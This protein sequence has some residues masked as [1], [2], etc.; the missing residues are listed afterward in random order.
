MKFFKTFIFLVLY[1][2]CFS[3]DYYWVGNS[4]NWS[5]YSNHWA[6]TSGGST[7][8]NAVPSINDDIYFDVNSF[9]SAGQVVT[10]DLS[11][12]NVNN[13]DFTGVTNSPTLNSGIANSLY[14]NGDWIGSLGIVNQL[15]GEIR[16]ISSNSTNI[17]SFG[18][19][20][21]GPIVFDGYGTWELLSDFNSN[22]SL[23]VKTGT[24]N[25][26]NFNVECEKIKI[27][28]FEPRTINAG[29]S[30]IT[31]TGTDSAFVASPI[32]LYLTLTNADLIFNNTSGN[33]V[34]FYSGGSSILYPKITVSSNAFELVE[35]STVS[36]F[37]AIPGTKIY[38]PVNNTCNFTSFNID[39]NCALPTILAANSPDT[40]A[41]LNIAGGTTVN[42]IHIQDIQAGGGAFVANNS[43]DNGNN[44]GW[45][46][47]EETSNGNVYWIG[48]TGNWSNPSNWSTNC[49]PGPNDTIIFNG[50]S[51]S[52]VND[53]VTL[54][55]NAYGN[56][57][58]WIGVSG[59]PDFSGTG[60]NLNLKESILFD[61]NM[62]SSFSGAIYLYGNNN[63][64][65]TTNGVLLNNNL[66]LNKQS[67]CV[68]SDTYSSTKGIELI[69]G[70]I[71]FGNFTHN[72]QN[73][74]SKDNTYTRTIDLSSS[75]LFLNGI[76][77]VLV[78][79]SPNLVVTSTSS[80]IEFN[81][82][83]NS[84]FSFFKS[85]LVNYDTV[86]IGNVSTHLYGSNSFKLLKIKGG[87]EFLI[88][89]GTEQNVDSIVTESS[90][91]QPSI[92]GTVSTIGTPASLNK[93]GY[94]TLRLN[95]LTVNHVVANALSGAYY[96]LIDGNLLNTTT[97]WVDNNTLTGKR[98]YWRGN[99][100]NWNDITKW[101]SPL[102]TPATCLPTIKDSVYFD[103]GSF[104]LPNQIVTLNV[105]AD[106]KIMDWSGSG[107]FSPTLS[108]ENSLNIK[109]DFITDVG[110]NYNSSSAYPSLNFIPDGNKSLF[111]TN[112]VLFDVNVS[113]D[114]AVLT[115]SVELNGTL[116]LG[117]DKAL[118]LY[119]GTFLSNNDSIFVG[120]FNS[121]SIGTQ[122]ADLGSSYIEV[123]S[124]FDGRGTGSLNFSNC[125]IHFGNG[126]LFSEFFGG[127]RLFNYLVLYGS[128]TSII[129]V[130]NSNS[131]DNFEIKKGSRVQFEA[132]ETQTISTSLLAIGNCENDTIYL[133]SISVNTPSTI[134]CTSPSTIEVCN[135]TDISGSGIN[136]LFGNDVGGNS[137]L[138]FLTTL[139]ATS[140]FN[141]SFDNC[142]GMPA[143]FTNTS[144]DYLSGTALTY[145]W[146]FGDG[147]T[148]TLTN[149]SH[150][151]A[152]SDLFKLT[153]KS[154]YTNGCYNI[155]EDSIRVNDANIV[156]TSSDI[157][158][159]ICAGDMVSFSVSSAGASNFNFFL[160][161][162]SVL[163]GTNTNY[164]NSNLVNG[165]SV[166][167]QVTLNGCVKSSTA[168]PFVVHN[169][170]TTN[171]MSSDS[172]NIICEGETVTFTASGADVYLFFID[173]VQ[174]GSYSTTNILTTTT[175]QNNETISVRG[176]DTITDCFFDAPVSYNFTV[177]PNPIPTV[178]VDDADLVICQSDLVNF[179]ASGANEY[180]FFINGI[181]QQGS[182]TLNT[183]STS[184]LNQADVVTVIGTT[185]GCSTLSADSSYWYVN[186]IPSVTL[187]NNSIGNNICE[188]AS[189]QFTSNGASSYEFFKN[190][191]SVQGPN[192]SVSYSDITVSSG[193]MYYVEGEQN[194]CTGTSLTT[195]ITTTPL[196][197][198][199]L[200]SSFSGSNICS[201]DTVDFVA[202]G[203][204][205]YTFYS[206]GIPISGNFSSGLYSTSS[207]S[208]G[209]VISVEG[210]SN[211]CSSFSFSSYSYTVEPPINLN[212]SYTTGLDT[213]CNGMPL[214][215]SGVGLGITQY[216]LNVNGTLFSSNTTGEFNGVQLNNGINVIT[217]TGV[218][219]GC[220]GI[221][222]SSFSVFVKPLPTISLLSSDLD[223]IICSN[224]S[225]IVSATGGTEYE[226]FIDGFTQGLMSSIDS[227]TLHGLSNG[228]VVT[229]E[230]QLNGCSSM[231]GNSITFIVNAVPSVSLSSSDIDNIICENESITFTANGATEY[232]YYLNGLPISG[233]S[234]NNI[235]YTDSLQNGQ[236]ISV[237]GK[238]NGCV[239]DEQFL[240]IT[241]N[242]L[243]VPLIT[244]SHADT[245]GCEGDMVT[246]Y[247]SGAN[248]Y[249]YFID[250]V[251]IGG[252]SIN[253]NYSTDLLM[254]NQTVTMVGT[255]SNGC[256]ANSA[257]TLTFTIK[258]LP[259][260]TFNTSP[261]NDTICNGDNINFNITGA[262]SINYYLNG[263]FELTNSTYSSNSI[264]N[265]DIITIN[266]YLNGC[267][268]EEDTNF[269]FIVL[270]YPNTQ[271][272]SLDLD[273][274]ICNGD[275]I[276]FEALGALNYEFFIDNVS[277]GISPND[278]LVFNGVS[279]THTVH[280]LGYNYQ[281]IT[282]SDTLSVNVN[283]IPTTSITS[284]SLNNEICFGETVV[285]SA[286]GATN[287]N[288]YINDVLQNASIVNN[289]FSIDY[290]E[291][292]DLIYLSGENGDC[293]FNS[294]TLDFTVHTM[295]LELIN[296]SNNMICS[297][298]IVSFTGTGADL[299]EFFINGQSVQASSSNNTYSTSSL[300]DG[301]VVVLEGYNSTTNCTQELENEHLFVVLNI[302]TISPL[303]PITS[304]EGE[305]VVLTSDYLNWN[306][307]SINT[308]EITG[309]NDY[310]YNVDSTGDYQT[311]IQLGGNNELE[312]FGNNTY[313]QLGDNSLISSLSV[314]PVFN[315][316]NVNKVESGEDFSLALNNVGDLY[317]WGKNDFGQLGDSTYGNKLLPIFIMPNIADLTT[318]D[319]FS[320]VVTGSK[321]VSAWGNNDFGQL[322]DGTNITR[323]VPATVNG[324]SNIVAVKAGKSHVLALD[325][326]GHVYTWGDNQ[327][328]QLGQGNLISN[329]T[330]TQISLPG[331]T[332][333][334]VGSNHSFAI[335]S[336][337]NTYAWGNNAE[338][339]LGT[340]SFSF[341]SSPTLINLN[342]I[343]VIDGGANHSIAVTIN[344]DLYTWGSNSNGQLGNGTTTSETLP[345]RINT[346]GSVKYAEAGYHNSFVTRNDNSVWSFGKNTNG[347][348]GDLSLIDKH[349][350]TH[351]REITGASDFGLSN[352]HSTVL[353]TE[354]TSCYSNIVEVTLLDA[355]EV[356][357]LE[358]DTILFASES[359]VYYQWFLNGNPIVTNGNNQSFVPQNPGHYSVTVTYANGCEAESNLHPYNIVSI[360]KELIKYLNLYPNPS[361]GSIT[362][363][364]S[365]EK[366]VHL[367]VINSLGMIIE[368]HLIESSKQLN[369]SKLKAGFYYAKFSNEK[370]F[371]VIRFEIVQ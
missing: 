17:N 356:S 147:N 370:N 273:L 218:R 45:T 348:L 101:E 130:Y 71:D 208:S 32:N 57:M 338:G 2:K 332:Q 365:G 150:V 166:W 112:D 43:I 264:Q 267:K 200:N 109:N 138:N 34:E 188:G 258:P 228:T 254:D 324:L 222:N 252:A 221:A 290:I 5:D 82:T 80:I 359:G 116:K 304:C 197:I 39:G 336:L 97:N 297:G 294:D 210:T 199:S 67:G 149:P 171:L 186:P 198:V 352:S 136:V 50:S 351:I 160:N 299:Y 21:N 233:Y 36:D 35:S 230:G 106:A 62:T 350:P 213:I 49:L 115:D 6:T 293:V 78:L 312:S 244:A 1:T 3:V 76:D 333:I 12:Q 187:T 201:T 291:D 371:E 8:H 59:M 73:F 238:S 120:T 23:S 255:S 41:S 347:Q 316:Y 172:D 98:F 300:Q 257:D 265:G 271:L 156:L 234:S 119:K 4:G 153:L 84:N 358:L 164:S 280:V 9:S 286:L 113:V 102:G 111:T 38:L 10:L 151:Y 180:E 25:T 269:Q 353:A 249:E 100:G 131:I 296:N 182:G 69:R 334:A 322:G 283:P 354:E 328:G 241:I 159:T 205:N 124:N 204:T 26:N 268:N 47:N 223:N 152:S 179:T 287:Y 189:I 155:Y 66:I 11:V 301:D 139:P 309:A 246:F 181:S 307:W 326:L 28:G 104:T 107:A 248:L 330:P 88:Q 251:S 125:E 232:I 117:N 170:P 282:S 70:S 37:S 133:S 127:G 177:N 14:V 93:T 89:G 260:L 274:T 212:F 165:D 250:N 134:N 229:V 214:S 313:G 224:D 24:I 174:Q 320:V 285:L 317:A 27:N 289:A 176:K 168:I 281:C 64:S 225:V 65:I 349:S 194:G 19:F 146:D 52:G 303:G 158:S 30:N 61:P 342:N 357:I 231:A 219:N 337:G 243:P 192:G 63:S 345:L 145:E 272:N 7:M 368:K 42:Y 74:L 60:Y 288:L 240:S 367:E 341:E 193:D 318:G 167:V 51:F 183:W 108:F 242:P 141:H 126:S 329:G 83:T 363:N 48:N 128:P 279:N 162:N 323:N 79:E 355:E 175:I 99:S 211:N 340:G 15:L 362:I 292:G 364:Y 178:M 90:C 339:Q 122:F 53:V 295:N 253:S 157:D 310:L 195:T 196:P 275:S 369:L 308:N 75:H 239:S 137:G 56:S 207:L 44:I 190:G 311:A 325:A 184:S 315:F 185:L 321:T 16:F 55:V 87:S 92:I 121:N 33:S 261:L 276:A 110:V 94:D 143:V 46:I 331:I 118:N 105:P 144:V 237:L 96:E 256:V 266:G 142:L 284:S 220:E 29:T 247:G 95:N 18:L 86:V 343:E 306:Q 135:I 209:E 203:A 123:F 277:Q 361:R 298:D 148:S 54:D 91:V 81:N 319:K 305:E 68:L 206:D 72:I 129:R 216:N 360:G 40:L 161:T 217:L 262:D 245:I 227:L 114:G 173:G 191:N 366:N 302:P 85:D 236:T 263:V 235:Y 22:S 140:G 169:L 13:I 344:G 77:E 215:F 154:T 103:G 327:Y 202:T 132:G 20:F 278:T 163:N 31:I 58:K 259:I 335:D 346:I 314:T 270:N 226:F